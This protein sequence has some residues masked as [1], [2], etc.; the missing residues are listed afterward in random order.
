MDADGYSQVIMATHSPLLMACPNARLLQISRFGLDEADF[1]DT[2]H[3]R[4]MREFCGDPDGFLAEAMHDDDGMNHDPYDNAYISGI[5]NSVT[6]IAIVG[7]SANDVR[8]SF[9]VTEISDRQG[10]R[11]LSRS[12]PARPARKSSAA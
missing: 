11:R 3:F 12:I 1:R 7:A 6:T 9:F 5:L 2:D 8:P 10:V 4:M